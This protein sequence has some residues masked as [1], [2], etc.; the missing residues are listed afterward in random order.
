MP[1]SNSVPRSSSS[2]LLTSSDWS[3][4]PRQF[5]RRCRRLFRAARQTQR[6]ALVLVS[7]AL[8]VWGQGNIVNAQQAQ[9]PAVTFHGRVVDARS[10]EPIAKV[11]IIVSGAAQST[12]TDAQGAFTLT[13]VPAGE[14][15][16]YITTVGYGLVKKMLIVKQADVGEVLIALNQEAASLTERVTIIAEPY[17]VSETNAPTEQTLN[18]TELQ[19]LSKVLISDPVRAVQ[20]LPGV[21]NNDD[22]R[23]EFAVRG[24]DYR[25][26]GFFVDGI[27]TD[28]FLHIASGNSEERVTISVINTDTISEVSLLPGAFPAKY[29]D[30]TAAVLN[31]STRDGNRI[32]P[33]FRFSTGLQFGTSGVADGPLAN[34]RGSWLFAARSSLLDY[35]SRGIDKIRS[36]NN[37]DTG[38]ID[39]SDVEG[40]V[41]LDLSSRNRI[42]IGG[43]YS[44]LKFNES[45][46]PN[47]FDPNSIFKAHSRNSLLN[48]FWNYTPNARLLVQ[49]RIFGSRTNF[50]SAN[51]SASTITD[52]SRTQFGAR[53]DLNFLV[54][55]A[56]RIESG[57][58]LRSFGARQVSN[59]F[60]LP[61]PGTQV[62]F[63]SFDRRAVEESAYLQDTYT[64]QGH[65][66]SLTG[67]LRIDHGGLAAQ[68]LVSPRAAL[69]LKFG[70]E[71]TVRAG[72]GRYAQ[73]PDFERLFGERGNP[74]LRAER[75]T[76][77]NLSVE[78]TF[79]SRYRAL[80]EIYDREDRDLLF[81]LAEPRLQANKVTFARLPFRNSLSGH[82]RG[83]EFT[84]QR[85]SANRLSGWVTYSYAT[86]LFKDSQ[87]G[88]S[89]PSDV[90][91]HHTLSAYGSYRFTHTFNVSSQWRY[92]S[93][94]PLPGFFRA[95]GADLFLSSERNLVRQPLYS[96]VDLRANK[97]FLFERW[98]LNLSAELLNITNH[99][100]FRLPV[101][102][103]IDATG[104]V[105]RRFGDAMP[106]LP[107]L[108]VAIEF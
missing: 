13:N 18:K 87:T 64:N 5:G 21:T 70:D 58:Y 19:E 59:F 2:A 52:E 91:Q 8:L 15:N 84:V 72:F 7:L 42:G 79:G 89:F 94:F 32:K 99:K 51:G 11:K 65:G 76:H 73:F 20:A 50:T 80:V 82:A 78:R 62:N 67:G 66:V 9:N 22:L 28:S 90:D 68:T 24:A 25:R 63:A 6:G 93:G 83:L 30:A 27:L 61:L 47:L 102:D 88:L 41:I 26:M 77:Y 86:S 97:A 23:A 39:F 49:T 36:N 95:Q 45:A 54:R 34:K 1:R 14:I 55:P 108:G 31:L 96:R 35:V 16:L 43:H 29:G 48:G 75:A 106:I 101:I 107:G 3:P 103:G 12:T 38:N 71:W 33:A 37:T 60:L 104:R 53:S 4:R 100:N 81:S 85:R 40:K 92:G 69:A 57:V 17:A 74:S 56:H 98:K 105:F 46:V 44:R 10:G